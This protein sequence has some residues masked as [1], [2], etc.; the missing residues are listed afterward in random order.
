MTTLQGFIEHI[1]FRNDENGYT[2]LQLVADAGEY[3][4]VGLFRYADEGERV[5]VTGEFVEHPV[6]GQQ[7][8]VE[9]YEVMTPGDEES[10]IR[11]LGSG[12][13]KG[14]GTALA[15]RIVEKFGEDTF[16]IIEEDPERL[17][18]IKGISTR[19]AREIATQ[20]LEKQDM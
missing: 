9:S 8:K 4:C 6:Y 1:I 3:T 14:I 15:T 18:E 13:I 2:V 19:K 16:R 7:L 20:F 11:Y 12:A 17:S 5:S 10:M